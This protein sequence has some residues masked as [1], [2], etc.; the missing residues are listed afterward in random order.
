LHNKNRIVKVFLRNYDHPS[1]WREQWE[2]RDLTIKGFV[3]VAE[4]TKASINVV[5]ETGV[6]KTENGGVKIAILEYLVLLNG[7]Q[8]EFF[9]KE[10][11]FM[12]KRIL[13]PAFVHYVI[14]K[15]EKELRKLQYIIF[16]I[17]KMIY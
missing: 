6:K 16:S 11:D 8:G 9:S 4:L 14:E 7:M 15:P 10:K 17:M 2:D 3:L 1:S 5:G 13:G 12:S